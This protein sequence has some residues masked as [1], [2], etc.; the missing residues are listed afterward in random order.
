LENT[1]PEIR[2]QG[3]LKSAQAHHA[4]G[5]NAKAITILEEAFH[6]KS[7]KARAD[8]IEEMKNPELFKA[9]M[10]KKLREMMMN[11]G[12]L[13]KKEDPKKTGIDALAHMREGVDEK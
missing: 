7:M 3:K 10:A 6:V 8:K 1:H 13:V 5:E 11:R 4:R 2:K 12:K 9:K